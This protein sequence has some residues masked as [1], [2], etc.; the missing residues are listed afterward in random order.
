M[1]INESDEKRELALKAIKRKCL[2]C[3]A[4][5]GLHPE[6]ETEKT[7]VLRALEGLKNEY[8]ELYNHLRRENGDAGEIQTAL[9]SKRVCM[10]ALD[11]CVKCERDFER[12]NRFLV[13]Y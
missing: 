1:R 13:G 10:D 3:N 7:A 6:R 2:L 12:V 11:L 8:D 5:T 9:D 4:R